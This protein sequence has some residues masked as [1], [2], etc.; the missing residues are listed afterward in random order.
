MASNTM[1][2]G[3]MYVAFMGTLNKDLKLEEYVVMLGGSIRVTFISALWFVTYNGLNCLIS[4][5]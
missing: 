3:C 4:P 2:A 5:F 1:A